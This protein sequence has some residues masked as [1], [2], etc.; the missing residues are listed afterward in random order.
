MSCFFR[1][2]A[3]CGA[4]PQ[5][6]AEGGC[7]VTADQGATWRRVFD[8][9]PGQQQA[10]GFAKGQGYAIGLAL[11]PFRQ[12]ELIVTAG[13]RPPGLLLASSLSCHHHHAI[14]A[15]MLLCRNM[16]PQLQSPKV[17]CE[18]IKM[19]VSNTVCLYHSAL[20]GPLVSLNRK[21]CW[22]VDGI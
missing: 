10:K 16:S 18:E 9:G 21:D 12:G 1:W 19:A 7:F 13:D 5:V 8:G 3:T 14:L 17:L 11:N 15:W 6:D 4:T 22:T 2:F 20:H